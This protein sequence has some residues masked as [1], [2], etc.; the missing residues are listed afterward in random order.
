M[1]FNIQSCRRKFIPL[2]ILCAVTVGVSPSSAQGSDAERPGTNAVSETAG[3][4]DEVPIASTLLA[5]VIHQLPPDPIRVTGKLLVRRLR[6]VPVKTYGFELI[7]RWGE[8]VP[9]T[10]YTIFDA[11]GD[12]LERL[13]LTHGV[14][15][16]VR[17]AVGGGD[18]AEV[19]VVALGR[20]IQQSDISW[21]DLTLS[22]LWWTDAH[23]EG[24]ES[25]RTF[26]CYIIRVNRPPDEPGP[27][28]SVRLWISKKAGMMLRAEGLDAT[29][30]PIRQ[31]WVHSVH[32]VDGAWMV[33][34]MEIQSPPAVQR[35]KLS[36]AEVE[37]L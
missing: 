10:Q 23:H 12:P 33:E 27:Y 6:G 14:P 3:G 7:A 22:F 26:D 34:N 18:L 11:F 13:E 2:T 8:D 37:R 16:R 1:P 36:I 32:K 29:G 4:D 28:H 17:H 30:K 31:L 19:P 20:Q 25:V 24:E 21:M 15:P 9:H 35:T 5:G